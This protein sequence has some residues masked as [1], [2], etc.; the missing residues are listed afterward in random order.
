MKNFIQTYLPQ[1]KAFMRKNA[2]LMI[3]VKVLKLVLVIF[4]MSCGSNS[5]ESAKAPDTI[6]VDSTDASLP[7]DTTKIDFNEDAEDSEEEDE[8]PIAPQES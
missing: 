2:L 3:S 6:L 4:L 1:L 5:T 8:N 7:G